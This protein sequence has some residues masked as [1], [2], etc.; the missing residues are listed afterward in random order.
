ML[1]RRLKYY[2]FHGFF[3]IILKIMSI[4]I[5][6]NRSVCALPPKRF[7]VPAVCGIKKEAR[8]PIEGQAP[9]RETSQ[10]LAVHN[11]VVYSQAAV[12]Q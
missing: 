2:P 1:F 4:S 6:P 3:Y 9:F 7:V 12:P 5:A 11:Q 8:P 10:P